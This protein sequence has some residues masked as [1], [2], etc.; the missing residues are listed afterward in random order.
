[1]V[2]AGQEWTHFYG[3]AFVYMNEGSSVDAMWADAKA[4][5][6]EEEAKWPYSFVKDADY[7]L[8]RGTV[9]GRIHLSTE[10]SLDGAWV[11]LAPAGERDWC[12]SSS[13]YEFWTK[14]SA[15]GR[16]TVGNVRPGKYALHVCGGNEFEDY[17]LD[18]VEVKAGSRDLGCLEWEGVQNGKLVWQIGRSDRSTQEYRN[19]EDVRHFSNATRY[20]C[21][22][23]NDV[24]F[25]I[26]E[27][28]E[29]QDWNFAQFGVYVGK[30]YWSVLF[31]VPA[32]ETKGKGTLTLAFAAFQSPGLIVRLNGKELQT[33]KFPKSGMSFYRCGGQDS[34][35][36]TAVVTFDASLLKAGQNE[37]QLQLANARQVTP[38]TEVAPDL[39]GGVMYDALRMEVETV[40]KAR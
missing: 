31:N 25:T 33:V 17:F 34:L 4:K 28:C 6:K 16:F 11:V 27:N 9:S 7:P 19:G 3:P 29:K 38:G 26:G 21:D 40:G 18:N 5:A 1:V 30:P 36:Q 2:A 24:T 22:F 15:D 12:M 32:E 10:A 39:V 20:A 35:R 37:L 8:E 23:P 13:G 14:A